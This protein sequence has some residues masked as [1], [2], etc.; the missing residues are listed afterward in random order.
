MSWSF[1]SLH[2]S[3]QKIV[4]VTVDNIFSFSLRTT[5]GLKN[6]LPHV[7]HQVVHRRCKSNSCKVA[8]RPSWW[9]YICI[10]QVLDILGMCAVLCSHLCSFV[11]S[12][13]MALLTRLRKLAS[14]NIFEM[15]VS[16][17]SCR[18]ILSALNECRELCNQS[19]DIRSDGARCSFRHD[20]PLGGHTNEFRTTSYLVFR[21]NG[22]VLMRRLR[23]KD[24]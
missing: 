4:P 21:N 5:R 15:I 9:I 8:A 20:A 24:C 1:Q 22:T 10:Q 19:S 23:V 11:F 18:R 3:Y 7:L 6:Q 13:R 14:A 16:A 12:A 17:P 2:S